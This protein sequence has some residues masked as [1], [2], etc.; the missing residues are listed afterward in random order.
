VNAERVSVE[1]DNGRVHLAGMVNSWREF[2]A[3]SNDALEAGAIS[4]V[5]DLVVVLK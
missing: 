3:A 2:S 1:F 5:N 4:V